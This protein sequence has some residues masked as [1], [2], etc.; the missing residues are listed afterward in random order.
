MPAPTTD[1]RP[2]RPSVPV[3]V[4]FVA[5]SLIWGS[6]FLFIKIGL[7]EGLPPFVLVSYRLWSAALFL[8]VVIRLTGG[9]LPRSRQAWGRL[10]VLG[11][12]NVAIPF[13]L[14]TWGEQFTSSA[15]AAIGN[16]L[17]PLFA[18]V[19]ASLVLHDEPITLNRLVGLVIGFI[20]AVLLASPS[21]GSGSGGS[22]Q[23]VGE[24]AVAVAS[25]S[26]AAAAVFA[27][28]QITGRPIINDPVRG[29]RTPTPVEIALPQVVI[30]GVITST[31]AIVVELG[32]PT[33]VFAPPTLPAWF[34]VLWLGLLGSGVAYLLLFRIIKAWGATRATMVTYLMP[35]VGITLGLIVLHE[36]L[37]P[38]EIVG[39]VLIISG[40][41][42]ANSKYGQ[43]RL[44]GRATAPTPVNPATAA[45]P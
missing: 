15:I 5:L 21:F 32:M 40:L 1:E 31:L 7:D 9:S 34:A 3:W 18:I 43:R 19:I 2:D 8:L 28:H 27:R 25:L 42:L 36:E 26:Y 4:S 11:I 6:S 39:T 41:L 38:V 14:I 13:S 44:Y 10:V 16:A 12:I 23:L 33:R 24:L 37:H 29:P 45:K 30:A 35:I 20:G 22:S 17:V